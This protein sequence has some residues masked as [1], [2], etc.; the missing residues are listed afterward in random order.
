MDWTD[1]P[2]W[3]AAGLLGNAVFFSRFL[4]QWLASERAGFSYVPRVFWHLSLIGSAFLL[5]YALHRRDPIFVLAYLPN[6][7]VYLRNLALLR[8]SAAIATSN[9]VSPASEAHDRQHLASDRLA[10]PGPG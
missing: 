3:L 8:R 2:R 1:D 10:R 5:A 6:G 9:G 4:V 7:F